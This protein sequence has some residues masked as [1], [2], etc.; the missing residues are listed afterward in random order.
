[1]N[2]SDEAPDDS[3][4]NAVAFGAAAEAYQRHR[5]TY[6]PALFERLADRGIG[7][8]GQQILDIGT[9]TGFVATAFAQRGADVVGVDVDRSMLARAT[10]SSAEHVSYMQARAEALPFASEAFEVVV[11]A[12]CWHWFDRAQAARAV[13]RILQPGG[14]LVITHFD[15]LPR[16]GNVVEAT[17]SLVRAAN[18]TWPYAGGDGCYPAWLDDVSDASFVDS[19]TFTFDVEVPY[20]HRDWRG[21]MQAS[22]GVGASLTRTEARSFDRRLGRVI[23]EEFP[24]EPL[25]VPHRSFT[26]VCSAP[27]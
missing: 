8:P 4:G 12:Q 23:E 11:A 13:R 27:P 21:R 9:G 22:A 1:M 16:P 6:P 15:W 10:D 19:E 26:L 2:Q 24:E 14:K 20:S 17:E 18:P 7:E 3:F 25:Q 5:A